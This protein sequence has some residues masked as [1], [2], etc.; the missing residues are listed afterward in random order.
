[1][2]H[3]FTVDLEDWYCTRAVESVLARSEWGKCESRIRVG[4]QKLLNLLEKRGIEATFFVLGYVAERDPELIREIADRG[5][6]IATHGY[7]HRSLEEMF[8]EEFRDDLLHSIEIIER[9]SGVKVSGF[10][11]PN[12]SLT[13]KTASW[14][15]DIMGEC[16]LL[17]DSSIFPAHTHP[18]HS[19]VGE[20]PVIHQLENGMIE[21]PVSCIELC[22]LRLPATGGAYFR[23]APFWL[24]NALIEGC[25]RQGSPA[26]FYIHPWEL[27]DEQP[28]LALPLLQRL[29]QYRGI[30]SLYDKL[31]RLTSRFQFTSI[32]CLLSADDEETEVSSKNRL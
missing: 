5:H 9:I 23:Q 24:S 31:E 21:A 22:G 11:A 18:A 8:P 32:R 15:L 4:T 3:L 16:H 26:L 12:F 2:Q 20:I 6:E 17:Y 28:R 19:F 25:E 30:A 27:D 1:M 14:A 10:R 7:A 29:R 13:K